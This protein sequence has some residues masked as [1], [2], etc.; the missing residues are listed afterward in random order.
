VAAAEVYGQDSHS[1]AALSIFLKLIDL[2][3]NASANGLGRRTFSTP[4]KKSIG[5]AFSR[6]AKNSQYLRKAN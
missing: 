2:E 6:Q 3:L 1:K 4:N 5:I